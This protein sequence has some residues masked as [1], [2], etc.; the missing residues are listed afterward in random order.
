MAMHTSYTS[1]THSTAAG[2]VLPVER[3]PRWQLSSVRRPVWPVI[4]ALVGAVVLLVAL[5]QVLQ[6]AV[7]QRELRRQA[8]RAMAEAT[9]HCADLATPAARS[10]CRVEVAKAQ[11]LD[12]PAV[13]ADVELNLVAQAGR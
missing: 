11:G 8:A 12:A 5:F 1:D 10:S 13:T 7:K 3:L 2:T 4:A 6:Q 9:W